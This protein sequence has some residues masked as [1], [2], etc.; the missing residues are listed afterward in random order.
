MTFARID[1][2]EIVEYPLYQGD[3]EGQHGVKLSYDWEGGIINDKN[4]VKVNYV[5]APDIPEGKNLEY[6]A[7]RQIAPNQW[8]QTFVISDIPAELL[9][10]QQII[11]SRAEKANR[12]L[13]ENG[14]IVPMALLRQNVSKVAISEDQPVSQGVNNI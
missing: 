5:V 4:Y 7:P 10:G 8:E 6:G 11:A 13:M 12:I 3:I 9:A 2:G 1:N 14:I